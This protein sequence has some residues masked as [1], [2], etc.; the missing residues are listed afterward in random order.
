MLAQIFKYEVLCE[1]MLSVFL[2]M[3]LGIVG[4]YGNFVFNFLRNRQIVF[5]GSYTALFHSHQKLRRAPVSPHSQHLSLPVIF[6]V[7]VGDSGKWG[8]QELL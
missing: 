1:H 8:L 7:C 5:Q 3:Y 6:K 4:S 2:V